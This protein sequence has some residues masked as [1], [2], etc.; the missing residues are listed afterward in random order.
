MAA[1]TTWTG[2]VTEIGP[3]YPFV[4][5]EMLMVVAITAFWIVWHIM[6]LRAESREFKE[7]A[8]RLRKEDALKRV[9]DR[10]G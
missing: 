7:D 10:E 2:N 6:Q 3:L 5:T 8:E 4:G 1:I 9:L